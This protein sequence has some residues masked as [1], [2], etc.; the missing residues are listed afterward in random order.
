VYAVG[1]PELSQFGH[2]MAAVLC[3]GAEA[4]LSHE[5]AAALWQIRRWRV[6][7]IEVSVRAPRDPRPPGIRVYQRTIL[8]VDDIVLCSNIPA[9]SPICTLVDLA[10]RLSAQQLE[11]AVNEADKLDL[12]DPET[13]RSALDERSGQPGVAKLRALLD[14]HTF[15]LMDSELERRF[16]RMARKAGLPPPLT[17]QYVNGFKVDFFWPDLG[18]VVETDGLR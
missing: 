14:R 6:R 17:Q 1:R 16:L 7:E 18:L 3:C 2:W 15:R 10:T 11:A 12:V 8:G 13:L 9:T 4:A 5:S